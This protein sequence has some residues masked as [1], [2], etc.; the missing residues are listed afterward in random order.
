MLRARYLAIGPAIVGAAVMAAP[1]AAVAEAPQ[2]SAA[3]AGQ[4]ITGN[5]G[6]TTLK[7]TYTCTT[8][9][10]PANHLFVAVKQGPKVNTTDHSSSHYAKTFYSTNWMS[11][12]GPNA[13]NCDGMEHTPG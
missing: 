7:V 9:D 8:T 12:E 10:T 11:D 2:P 5:G 6:P 3:Y 4:L 13:L 1:T